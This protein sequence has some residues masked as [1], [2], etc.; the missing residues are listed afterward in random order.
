MRADGVGFREEAHDIGGEGVGGDVVVGRLVAE[1]K[2]AHAS[3]DQKGLESVVTEDADDGEG[4]LF[5]ISH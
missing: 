4:G 2:V 5:E 3:A 1:Q